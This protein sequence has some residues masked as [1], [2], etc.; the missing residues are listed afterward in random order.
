MKNKSQYKKIA[1][2]IYKLSSGTS[3]STD[4][5]SLQSLT[6]NTENGE[7]TFDADEFFNA[8]AIRFKIPTK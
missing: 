1:E 4:L 7:K 6:E 3:Q 5:Q 8:E 2:G